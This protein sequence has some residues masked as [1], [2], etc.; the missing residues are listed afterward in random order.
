MEFRW[1][2]RERVTEKKINKKISY[3]LFIFHSVTLPLLSPHLNSI[4]LEIYR[5]V[6]QFACLTGFLVHWIT[7]MAEGRWS[8]RTL[9]VIPVRGLLMAINPSLLPDRMIS[10]RDGHKESPVIENKYAH[11]HL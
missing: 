1:R 3:F 2:E 4:Y 8:V 9:M 7:L 5:W 10:P 11:K 6:K